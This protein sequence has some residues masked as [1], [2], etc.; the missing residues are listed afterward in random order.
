MMLL[1]FVAFAQL[2]AAPQPV[3]ATPELRDLIARAVVANHAPPPAFRGY[4]AHV[5]TELSLLMRDTLG[6]ERAA[7]IEQL[8]SSVR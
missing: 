7:Q 5:E 4:K 1:T 6:R 2:A 8:A 3:Y